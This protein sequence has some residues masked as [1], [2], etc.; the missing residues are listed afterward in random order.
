MRNLAVI[1]V[2]AVMIWPAVATAVYEI[3]DTVEDFTLVDLDGQEV[4]LYDLSGQ[5][6]LLNFF[7]TWCPGCNEEAA[8]LQNLWESYQDQDVTVLA[9]DFQEPAALVQGWALANDV[10]YPIWLA[11]DWNLLPLFTENGGIP[12]NTVLD[13]TMVLRYSQQGFDLDGI[14]ELLEEVLAEDNV[15]TDAASWSQVKAAYR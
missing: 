12:Y 10:T 5:V 6:I 11:P 15:A 13:R 2:I 14:T 8:H 3:G 1:T 9:V 7:T 4:S